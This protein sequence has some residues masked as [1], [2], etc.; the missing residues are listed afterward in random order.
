MV[1]QNRVDIKG[2]FQLG[3]GGGR[4]NLSI[5]K[6]W[7]DN[8]TLSCHFNYQNTDEKVLFL[9]FEFKSIKSNIIFV[10]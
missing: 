2:G 5:K 7:N 8:K 6:L 1:C 10:F 9:P 3:E 4:G